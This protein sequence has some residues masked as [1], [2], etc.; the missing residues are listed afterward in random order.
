[1]QR[2]TCDSW[3]HEVVVQHFAEVRSDLGPQNLTAGHPTCAAN[4]RKAKSHSLQ[5][6]GGS[7]IS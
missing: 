4:K 1:M 3:D 7:V 5:L 2:L 6:T